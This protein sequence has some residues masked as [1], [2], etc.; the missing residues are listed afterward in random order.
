MRTTIYCSTC[1]EQLLGIWLSTLHDFLDYS[2][3]QPSELDTILIHIVQISKLKHGGTMNSC[4]VTPPMYS[5]NIS[6]SHPHTGG[7][8]A[9][10]RL[11]KAA[12][13]QEDTVCVFSSS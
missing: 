6:A 4:E 12:S 1:I 2:S 11:H 8:I 3:E 9:M 10:C 13:R 5:R 7:H